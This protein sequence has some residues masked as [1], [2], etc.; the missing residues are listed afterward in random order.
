MLKNS[1]TSSKN[2]IK[3]N[4]LFNTRKQFVASK[5]HNT[6]FDIHVDWIAKNILTNKIPLTR[7]FA[8]LNLSLFLYANV[9]Y[10][11]ENRWK[12]L[13]GVSY[14]L[15]NYQNKDYIPLFASLLG[16]Y[17]VDDLLLETGIL[18]TVGHRLEKLYGTPFIFKMFAFSFYIGFLSSLYWIRSNAAKRERYFVEQPSKRDLGT[19]NSVQYRFMSM[20]G[21]TMSLVYFTLYKNARLRL[22]VLPLLAADMAVWGP[23]YSPAVLTGVAAG[24]IL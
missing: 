3:S 14:S 17:R 22:L 9:R 20:H 8:I 6:Y 16:S 13:E 24:M 5:R 10:G 12:A 19:P 2:I 15:Q 23:Y 7:A 18:L 21:F 1:F 11:W 4:L